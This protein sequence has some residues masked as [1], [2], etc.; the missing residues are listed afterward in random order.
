MITLF[1]LA[2]AGGILVGFGLALV[3]ASTLTATQSARRRFRLR[4]HLD[5]VCRRDSRAFSFHRAINYH[6]HFFSK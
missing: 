5:G 4:R 3:V 1:T 6:P 2:F